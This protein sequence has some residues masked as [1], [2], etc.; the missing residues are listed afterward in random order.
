M[1]RAFLHGAAFFVA[2]WACI[3]QTVS[4]PNGILL[5]VLVV[6][7]AVVNLRE[8]IDREAPKS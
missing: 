8:L 4:V 5:L 3:G 7:D 1:T 6:A 2:V